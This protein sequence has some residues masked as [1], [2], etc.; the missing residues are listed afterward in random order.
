MH[1]IQHR[2]WH[3]SLNGVSFVFKDQ[4]S[5]S[6][7]RYL[8][9]PLLSFLE[10]R[11]RERVRRCG[12]GGRSAGGPLAMGRRGGGRDRGPATGS[13]S[14]VASIHEDEGAASSREREGEIER[15]IRDQPKA[16]DNADLSN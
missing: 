10:R 2:P 14:S 11:E 3:G 13:T 5:P 15:A 12:C 7:L 6:L 8:G 4:M 1:V 16:T 9:S